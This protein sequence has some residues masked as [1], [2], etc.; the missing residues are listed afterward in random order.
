MPERMI[1]DLGIL[2]LAQDATSTYNRLKQAGGR[3]ISELSISGSQ[4]ELADGTSLDILISDDE[5]ASHA[6]RTPNYSPDGAPVIDLPY[7]VLMKLKAS[8]AQDL[9]DISRM[10]GA[11]T[12]SSLHA[13]RTAIEQYLPEALEDLESL[14][15]LGQLE[16]EA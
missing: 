14:A 5:W 9:A 12:E 6:L 4:W 15:M 2:I 10:L 1:L 8:R 7:L 13:V 16:Y 11:A 3:Q